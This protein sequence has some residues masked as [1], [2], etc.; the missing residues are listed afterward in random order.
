MSLLQAKA[1]PE[2]LSDYRG[3]LAAV[4]SRVAGA[5]REGFMG[6]SGERV[7]EAERQAL[8][9]IAEAAGTPAE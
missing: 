6:M 5:H 4:A 3:F 2:E 7:S 9:D 1:T 8:A